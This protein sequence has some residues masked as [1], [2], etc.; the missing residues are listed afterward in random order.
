[1]SHHIKKVKKL[2]QSASQMLQL[3]RMLPFVLKL[4]IMMIESF[5][6]SKI[7]FIR[8]ERR[9]PQMLSLR[10][11]VKEWHLLSL[12]VGEIFFTLEISPD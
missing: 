6:S 10:G 8:M 3:A 5:D 4:K 2:C 12:R 11:K 9:S 1:M 7:D